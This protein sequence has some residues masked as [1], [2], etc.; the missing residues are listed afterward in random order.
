MSA[1]KAD[2]KTI[3]GQWT[4]NPEFFDSRFR[5]MSTSNLYCRQKVRDLERNEMAPQLSRPSSVGTIAGL[6][7]LSSRLLLLSRCR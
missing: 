4:K 3:T 7:F 1:T 2:P 5:R 6:G